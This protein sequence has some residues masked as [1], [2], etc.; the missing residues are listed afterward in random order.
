[1]IVY[2]SFVYPLLQGAEDYVFIYPFNIKDGSIYWM[3]AI[4]MVV[5]LGVFFINI[6]LAIPMFLKQRQ[7][8][9][10]LLFLVLI[11]AVLFLFEESAKAILMALFDLPENFPKLY[12]ADFDNLPM[13]RNLDIDNRL[14]NVGFL[15]LSF[16]YRYLKDWKAMMEQ[17]AREQSILSEKWKTEFD[18]LKSQINPH[19]LFNNL[20]NIYAITERNN[21]SEASEA[22]ARLSNLMRFM[23]YDSSSEL[24]PVQKEINYIQDYLDIQQLRYDE[25]VI[26][27]FKIEGDL[28]AKKVSPF[29]LIPF[30][31]N[32][33]KYGVK[34]HETS[35]IKIFVQIKEDTLFFETKNKILNRVSNHTY[36][37]IGIANVKKRLDL[38]YA[39]RYELDID[40]NE[41]YF[42]VKLKISGL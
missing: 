34:I 26:V 8:V 31:E 38:V 20:N 7:L 19:F 29:L 41:E 42:I 39:D 28:S 1:M 24:I 15:I 12:G 4:S 27:N 6:Y 32:A 18:Y 10:Y 2:I 5:S 3:I 9:R 40:K 35:I 33:F 11:F 22:I 16:G 36:S 37:G 21:D 23:L 13:R 25:E 14:R 17:Q 30:V